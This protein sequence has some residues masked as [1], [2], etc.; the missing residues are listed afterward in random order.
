[1]T[2]FTFNYACER[3]NKKGDIVYLR[4]YRLMPFPALQ[5]GSE[6]KS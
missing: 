6:L 4:F 1:M 2:G 3:Q 5:H